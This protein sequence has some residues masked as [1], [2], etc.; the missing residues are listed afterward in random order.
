MNTQSKKVIYTP[1]SPGK[2]PGLMKEFIYWLQVEKT[3]PSILIAGIAQFQ[4]LHIHPFLDG[5]GRSARLLST[6]YLYST[7]YDFKRLF[8]ISEYYDRNR[9]E[10]YRKIQK[11]RDNEMDMTS[12]LEYFAEGLATQMAE[13][14]HVGENTIKTDVVALEH[15]LSNRQKLMMEFLLENG[16][17]NIEDLSALHPEVNKRTLQRD[18]SRLAENNLIVKVGR[19]RGVFY[20][21]SE[22]W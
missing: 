12:W 10:Y 21:L 1:P 20:L 14:Q 5:N 13:I 19:G 9:Q 3:I 18:V 16:R 7:G 17:F 8:T 22:K 15:N 11:V 6:L 4:M 2:V